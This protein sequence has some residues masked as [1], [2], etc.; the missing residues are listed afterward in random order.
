MNRY[1]FW[2]L[3]NWPFFMSNYSRK[4]Q[5]FNEESLVTAAAGLV[6]ATCPFCC[7]TNSIKALRQLKNSTTMTVLS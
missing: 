1:Y 2:F 6:Q 3:F 7:Q 4:G 5:V